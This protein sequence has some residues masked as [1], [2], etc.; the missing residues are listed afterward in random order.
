[1]AFQVIMPTFGMTGGEATVTRWFKAIGDHVQ[2]D[3]PLFEAENDK[4]NLEVPAPTTGVLLQIVASEGKIVPV[5]AVVGWIGEPDERIP[6]GE[7]APAA[8]S[9]TTAAPTLADTKSA[10][11]MADA[12]AIK[13]SPIAR[14]LAREHNLDL[15]VIQGSGPGGRIVE[16]DLQALLRAK[17]EAASFAAVTTSPGGELL[18]LTSLRRI[19]AERLVAAASTTVAVPLFIEVDMSEVQR[20]RAATRDEYTQRF[21]AACSYNA[22]IMRACAVAL[23]QH[24][25]LNS[26]WTAQGLR[27][28]PEIHIGLAV[29]TDDGLLVPVVQHADQK[30][31]SAIELLLKELVVLARQRRLSPPQMSGGTFTIT[32]LGGFGIETFVPVINP[33]QTAILGIGQ[34]T[35]QVVA[36]DGQPTVR[37]RM[38]LCLVFDH[39]AVDGAPAAACLARIKA[40]LENPYLLA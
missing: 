34:I 26:Q 37:P 17:A 31:I 25:L 5:E 15:G 8:L 12:A 27:L 16:K 24:P 6:T 7:K 33:P 18:P 1:M 10:A 21:G 4:A 2:A 29:A 20:L 19:T 36:I 3:E 23:R 22:M 9:G 28:L 40:L 11:R 32:N 13:A 38:K 30:P 39:R 14:R 35:D